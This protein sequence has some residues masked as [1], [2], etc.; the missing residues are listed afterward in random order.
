MPLVKRVYLAGPD[1]FLADA[2]DIGR[3][4][5]K[6]C[7][8]LGYEG[9][10][11]LDN[12]DVVGRDA[13]S[14][15]RANCALMQQ[16]D[17]GLF[18]LTPFRGPSADAGTVFEL[19]YMYARGKPVHGYSSVPASYRARVGPALEQHAAPRDGD[20]YAIEDF[21][22]IDNLMI[23]RAILEA[24]GELTAIEEK[25]GAR[26]SASLAAFRAFRACLEAISARTDMARTGK[27]E[28]VA[29]GG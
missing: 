12:D 22:L 19:G 9:L 16:A 28:T 15:F 5:Q 2:R 24:G 14:I 25:P 21:G 13:A 27:R 29:K 8:E 18:N 7:R 20:G 17:I 6:I 23:V 1:V 10:F 26:H 4:K 11:P 3:R